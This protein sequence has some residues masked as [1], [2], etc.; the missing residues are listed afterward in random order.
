[1]LFDGEMQIFRPVKTQRAACIC[2]WQK[3]RTK[4]PQTQVSS[5]L[6]PPALGE[7]LSLKAHM[8]NQK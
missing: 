4:T 6:L 8:K 5:L 7:S 3:S 2:C 1:M